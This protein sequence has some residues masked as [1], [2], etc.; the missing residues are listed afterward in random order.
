MKRN[1]GWIASGLIGLVLL[2][3]VLFYG[4][5]EG[6]RLLWINTALYSSHYQFLA[7]SL[8]SKAYI[9]S[10]L[11]KNKAP[12]Q[13]TDPS[14][15]PLSR[16]DGLIFAEIKGN[17]YKGY[18]LKIENP[19]RLALVRAGDEK[20]MLLE[21]M[22]AEHQ[23]LG[24]VNA[25]GYADDKQRGRLSGTT[26]MDG[27]VISRCTR[28]NTHTIGGLTGDDKL[29]VGNF[30]DAE[31]AAQEYRWA[32]EFGPLLIVNSEKIE[33]SPYSGGISPR[34]AIGQTRE[35][36]ILLVV[37]DGRQAAS[38]GATYQDI[39]TILYA[40]GAV[41]AMG[42]DG[43]SSSTM[44]YQGRVVNKPSE[45]DQERLLPNALVFQ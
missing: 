20:G 4:P 39:Q 27:L 28:G 2:L 5:F 41:N 33:L 43:G 6:F 32:V 38:I 40:N 8:Y 1:K 21:Q 18:L 31:I 19:Q 14:P 7:T 16:G 29:V 24:G 17:Y 42:L 25:S 11:D 15:L 34:T 23:G 36:H 26:I 22:V 30:T 45:G 35:G 9:Q 13:K 44:V 3:A 10:V 37:V 12:D